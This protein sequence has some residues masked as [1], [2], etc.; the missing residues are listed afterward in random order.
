MPK[1]PRAIEL[2]PPK[3]S[4][5]HRRTCGESPPSVLLCGEFV[6]VEQAAESVAPTDAAL[7]VMR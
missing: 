5:P 7:A 3:S 2:P 6:L 1:P 4:A